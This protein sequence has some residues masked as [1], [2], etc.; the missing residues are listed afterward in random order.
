MTDIIVQVNYDSQLH[1]RAA[2][3][4][5]KEREGLR[6]GT[7]TYSDVL[8]GKQTPCGRYYDSINKE[9]KL[10]SNSEKMKQFKQCIAH[11]HDF[12]EIRNKSLKRVKNSAESFNT[13]ILFSLAS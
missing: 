1:S 4:D 3:I 10:D 8:Y 7:L 12:Y 2:F 5:S 6:Y 13:R 9:T 11:H